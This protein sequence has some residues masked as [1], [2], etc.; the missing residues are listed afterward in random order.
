M[1]L[2][3]FNHLKPLARQL[4]GP[5]TRMA[6]ALPC[7]A[8]ARCQ[9]KAFHGRSAGMLL[10]RS[11]RRTSSRPSGGYAIWR[12]KGDTS[13]LLPPIGFLCRSTHGAEDQTPPC[14]G[15][16]CGVLLARL[17]PHS[18][19]HLRTRSTLRRPIPRPSRAIVQGSRARRRGGTALAHRYREINEA[20]AGHTQ[21]G[22]LPRA[23]HGPSSCQGGTC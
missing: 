2:R 21:A 11:L 18:C 22:S 4:P 19:V 12:L 5:N 13:G 15:G 23:C 9:L 7:Q 14:P 10:V 20:C 16:V 1:S 8:K 6:P 3:R 17:S